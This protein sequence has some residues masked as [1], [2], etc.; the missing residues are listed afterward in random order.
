MSM[1]TRTLRRTLRRRLRGGPNATVKRTPGWR[2]DEAAWCLI[3]VGWFGTTGRPR[4]I[5]VAAGLILYWVFGPA[6]GVFVGGNLLILALEILPTAPLPLLATELILFAPIALEL[7]AATTDRTVVATNGAAAL[8]I[9]GA[10]VGGTWLEWS[11][12][13]LT[14]V[15]TGGYILS[16]VGMHVAPRLSPPRIDS[17]VDEPG[18]DRSE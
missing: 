14:A 15:V 4:D 12:P 7:N 5:A 18:G 9:V 10:A 17:Q 1:H 11:M 13:R 6:I 3:A 2:W 8:L 16:M